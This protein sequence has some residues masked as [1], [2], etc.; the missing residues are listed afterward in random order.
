M[1]QLARRPVVVRGFQSLVVRLA[2]TYKRK[3][4]NE[5]HAWA[6][7]F[8]ALADFLHENGLKGRVLLWLMES[9]SKLTDRNTWPTWTL[10]SPRPRLTVVGAN[11]SSST[12]TGISYSES[13]LSS[14][15]TSKTSLSTRSTARKRGWR[16]RDEPQ[17]RKCPRA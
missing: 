9:A 11:T 15:E 4:Y 8:L 17:R 12:T 1:P 10:S 3:G 5:R 6:V 13:V 16:V 14:P 7:V 2:R